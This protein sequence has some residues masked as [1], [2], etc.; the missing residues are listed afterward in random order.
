MAQLFPAEPERPDALFDDLARSLPDDYLV[1]HHRPWHAPN[2]QGTARDSEAAFVIAHERK[3]LLVL[4]PDADGPRAARLAKSLVRRLSEL[5]AGS[6]RSWTATPAVAFRERDLFAP[7][8]LQ[9]D[10]LK[11]LAA[12]FDGAMRGPALG[13]DGVALLKSL[14]AV[15]SEVPSLTEHE[16]EI[17]KLT[18]AQYRVLDGLQRFRR[19]LICGCA[20]SGKTMLAAEKVKRLADQGLV[21][22]YVCFNQRL[23]DSVRDLLRGWRNAAV[24]NFHG[25]CERWVQRAKV[26]IDRKPGDEYFHRQLPDGLLA[27]ARKITERFDAIVVDEGQDFL[28]GWWRPLEATL[29]DERR[30]ILYVFYDDNQTLYNRELRFPPVDSQFDLTENVRNV[31]RVHDLVAKF[32][33]MDRK[34]TSRA[35]PGPE[36][37][38]TIY[39]TVPDLVSA[40]EKTLDRWAQDDKI[41]PQH[42]AILTGH[43]KEKS[44]V[45]RQRRFAGYELVDHA[46]GPG[47]ILWSSVHSF[48]GLERAAVILAEVEPLSHSELDTMLYV[49]CSRARVHLAVIAS[50]AAAELAALRK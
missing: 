46:P 45:W 39:R 40:V 38:I 20:G 30:G 32:Y 11:R 28:P 2:A 29:K 21:P 8:A 35:S 47:Q 19:V 50:E 9:R 1:F 34:L 6:G 17:A 13:F 42:I 26:K 7:L 37:R 44:A 3:G 49:G 27:A 36:P 22:L 24:D 4:D 31:R 5:P 25:L 15:P 10:D 43:G 41:G 48:K 12:W 18:V 23:R 16:A 14:L 33:R